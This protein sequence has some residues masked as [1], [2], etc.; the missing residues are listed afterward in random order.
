MGE[1]VSATMWETSLEDIQMGTWDIQETGAITWYISMQQ[2]EEKNRW[3]GST[4]G[5][6]VSPFKGL[7]REPLLSPL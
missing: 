2:K 3:Q 1:K 7:K 4:P 5:L 6:R